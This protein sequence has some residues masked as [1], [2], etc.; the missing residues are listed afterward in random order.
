MGGAHNEWDSVAAEW[1]QAATHA[2]AGAAFQSLQST[3]ER[4]AMTLDGARV[5][6]F[7]AG[8]GLLTE[9]LAAH[10]AEVLAVDTSRAML[11]ALAQKVDERNWSGV[12]TATDIANVTGLHDLIVCSSVCSFLDDYPA[13]AGELA[14][15]L[16]P[17]G[18][19]VQ[20]DWER[21]GTDP[22]GHGLTR[23]EI[24]DALRAAGLEQIHVGTAFSVA[25]GDETMRPVLGSGRRPNSHEQEF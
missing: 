21:D 7:G 22:D 25:F 19:F 8:T 9:P 4:H 23:Q 24:D 10:G 18:L 12:S 2:Y 11:D 3:L 6:D 1:D 13:V 17:G 14:A 16:R 5:I 20:W 15:L